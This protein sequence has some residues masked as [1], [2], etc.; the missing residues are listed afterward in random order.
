MKND[1]WHCDSHGIKERTSTSLKLKC[2][3]AAL[4][5]TAS[6]HIHIKVHKVLTPT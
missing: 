5:F 1:G 6:T 2:V 4:M 3:C